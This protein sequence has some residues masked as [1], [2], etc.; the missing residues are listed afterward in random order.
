MSTP[1]TVPS[2]PTRAV[3]FTVEKRDRIPVR[4]RYA[5]A[6]REDEE[7]IR[8][9][10]I[11]RGGSMGSSSGGAGGAGEAPSAMADATDSSLTTPARSAGHDATPA[12]ASRGKPL[13][14]LSSMAT[15]Q[16]V[17]GPAMIKSE[18]GRLLNYVTLNV[19]GRDIVGFVDEARRVVAE[20]VSLPEGV[21]IE[22]S[23]E[24][25]HQVRDRKSV[26]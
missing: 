25:E 11:S 26:V 21:H 10:L 5:R 22:W 1:I 3:T 8:R 12:H 19:R 9:L 6:S 20:K 16:I 2:H 7:S 18:N 4:I 14:P 24:F 13:I 15:V 17:E 23:G